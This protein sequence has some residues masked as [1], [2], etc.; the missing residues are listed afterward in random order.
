VSW[1]QG[2]YRRIFF[3]GCSQLEAVSYQIREELQTD[4]TRKEELLREWT[5]EKGPQL[6]LDARAHVLSANRLGR[7]A[8]IPL[9]PTG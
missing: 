5:N 2:R 4:E 9:T 6:S 3:N 8:H 7:L 1:L